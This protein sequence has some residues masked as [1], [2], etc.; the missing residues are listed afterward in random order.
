MLLEV[1]KK[2]IVHVFMKWTM[3]F[4][5]VLCHKAVMRDSLTARAQAN[6][7]SAGQAGCTSCLLPLLLNH[8]QTILFDFLAGL[9]C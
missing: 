2:K 3:F 7:S 9:I 1:R 6:L 4:L 8:R 5:C